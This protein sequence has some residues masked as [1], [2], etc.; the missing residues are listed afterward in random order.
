[1]PIVNSQE[2]YKKKTQNSAQTDGFPLSGF[3]SACLTLYKHYQPSSSRM[4]QYKHFCVDNILDWTEMHLVQPQDIFCIFCNI[5]SC[6]VAGVFKLKT[7]FPRPFA[8]CHPRLEHVTFVCLCEYHSRGCV[9]VFLC[10]VKEGAV[11]KRR[12]TFWGHFR[13][14][15]NGM[16]LV[17]TVNICHRLED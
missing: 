3:T 14:T 1:M 4:K 11:T 7:M 10:L 17:D 2:K 16:V 13:E 6:T 15:Q 12:Q 5:A 8:P 9:E